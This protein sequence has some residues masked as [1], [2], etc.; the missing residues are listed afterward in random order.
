MAEVK[1][2]GRVV[3]TRPDLLVLAVGQGAEM[4]YLCAPQDVLP[5]DYV[6]IFDDGQVEVKNRPVPLR[7]ISIPTSVESDS[8]DHS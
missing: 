7:E 3:E 6:W 5:G 4:P 8:P 1:A 2:Q